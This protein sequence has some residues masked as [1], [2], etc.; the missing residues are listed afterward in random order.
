MYAQHFAGL[1]GV[2]TRT[3]LCRI[4]W[5]LNQNQ[6]FCPLKA[7]VLQGAKASERCRHRFINHCHTH[8]RITLCPATWPVCAVVGMHTQSRGS[9]ALTS[10]KN[11]QFLP[12]SQGWSEVNTMF[13]SP[14]TLTD[15]NLPLIFIS[16]LCIFEIE[17]WWQRTRSQDSG[18]DNDVIVK[19]FKTGQAFIER[20]EPQ[21]HVWGFRCIVCHHELHNKDK[22]R[23]CSSLCYRGTPGF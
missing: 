11:M 2:W 20:A 8:N 4:P 14:Q 23:A 13:L 7:P 18:R 19:V 9:F 17:S 1:L 22:H 15:P 5:C 3:A 6:G 16:W 10:F 12:G 21:L